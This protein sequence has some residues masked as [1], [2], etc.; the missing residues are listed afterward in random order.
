MS[1]CASYGGL[2]VILSGPSG[3]GKDTV[4]EKLKEKMPHMCLSV[5]M[6]TRQKRKEETD[7]KDYIFTDFMDFDEKIKQGY[8]LEYAKYGENYYGTPKTTIENWLNEGK[9]VFLKIEVQGAQK[10]RSGFAKTISIFLSTPTFAELITRLKARK[11][12]CDEDIAR[13]IEIARSELKRANEYDY[14]VINDVVD[15]AADDICA[16]IRAEQLKYKSMQKYVNEVINN[17]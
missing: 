6:T 5:S 17:A 13:R 9:I 10:I 7:R 4:L 3:V 16:I 1:N 2:L 8:F 12:E 14:I 11:S 15:R